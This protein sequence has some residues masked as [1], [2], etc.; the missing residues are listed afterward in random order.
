MTQSIQAALS[1]LEFSS[2]F[3]EDGGLEQRLAEV[4]SVLSD[5]LS[6]V[7]ATLREVA[8]DGPSPG[9]DASRYMVALGGKRVRPMALL[10]SAACF[11]A[12]P[13]ASRQLAVCVELV[14][15]ATLLHDDVIDDGDERR[16]RP[17]ARVVWGNAVS[18]LA[19]DM[20]LTHALLLAQRH[21]PALMN[22][23]LATLQKLVHGEIVQLRGRA[24]LEVSE[25]AY[26]TILR[27][28]TASL[29]RFSTTA[30]AHLAGASAQHERLLGDFGESL[31]MAFQLVDD[32]LDYSGE[33]T[34][35]TMCADLRQGKLTLPLVLAVRDAPELMEQ[36]AAIRAG[37]D[38]GLLALRER[39]VASGACNVVRSRALGYTSKAIE[40]LRHLP[41]SP[42]RVLLQSVAQQLADRTG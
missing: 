25:H 20:L 15:S 22:G 21:A 9:M 42:A 33:R 11:G 41:P 24:E 10:L 1:S 14:H 13:A 17:A 16:G 4:Q 36:L 30:G 31:G 2:S 12:V 38:S 27:D 7:E 26:Q 5:D 8:A 34:G 35:K 19:G 23:L 29:F 3:A 39:V 28:K 37:D 6:W 18:V 40:H 32:L